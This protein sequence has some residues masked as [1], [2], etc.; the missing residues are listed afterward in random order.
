MKFPS[1]TVHVTV[2]NSAKTIKSCVDSLLRLNYPNKKIIVTD[3][4]STD[5]TYEIL[6]KY[7]HKIKLEKVRGP[8]PRAHNYI[9]PKV[10]TE[11]YA[12]TDAD[13]VV[14][15]NWLKNLISSFTSKEIIA[16]G[17]FVATP[18]GV[19]KL[20]SLIGRE[21]EYRYRKFPKYVSRFP[22]MNM[23]V[24]TAVAKKVK[25][26]ENLSAAFETDWGFRLEKYGKLAYVP[27]AIVWHYPRANLSSYFKQ[28]MNYTKYALR[29]Y[30]SH[31]LKA[32]GDY[33]S[34]KSMFLQEYFFITFALLLMSTIVSHFLNSSIS[35]LLGRLT[36]Y[37]FV[38]L[39]VSYLIDAIPMSKN[40]SDV[41]LYQGLF[42]IRN[43]SWSLG[44]LLGILYL[45]KK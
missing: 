12:M 33:I 11:F 22:T 20:Q 29:V 14:D 4:Y 13:C 45:F 21:L 2:K 9:I 30:T 35:Y 32:K 31:K 19:N 16:A 34:T 1:V 6:K 23:I 27:K 41:I 24:R 43:I 5:G 37:S 25:M 44:F 38:L 26:N 42:F 40:S 28:Q 18:R 17:G 8:A 7:G 15:R 10:D 3:A 39:L 36:F